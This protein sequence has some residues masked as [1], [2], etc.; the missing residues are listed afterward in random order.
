[1]QPVNFKLEEITMKPEKNEAEKITFNLDTKKAVHIEKHSEKEEKTHKNKKIMIILIS[2]FSVMFFISVFFQIDFTVHNFSLF[3]YLRMVKNLFINAFMTILNKPHNG[4]A[5]SGFY[6]A[7]LVS[8][9]G[10][11]LASSGAVYQGLFRNPIASA[12]IL[13]VYEGGIVAIAIYVLFFM[14]KV[15]DFTL[16]HPDME[17]IMYYL[18]NVFVFSGSVLGIVCVVTITKIAGRGKI[19]TFILV[20]TGAVFSAFL[21]GII[22]YLHYLIICMDDLAASAT[23]GMVAFG[24]FN[25]PPNPLRVALTCVPIAICLIAFIILRRNMNV[26]VFGDE[27]AQALGANIKVLQVVLIILSTIIVS[28]VITFCGKIA[29]LGLV[30]PHITRFFTG[31]DYKI[32]LPASMLTGAIFTLFVYFVAHAFGMIGS[33]SIFISVLGFVVFVYFL[34]KERRR[35]NADWA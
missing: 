21:N 35:K 22:S 9:V 16:A 30:V 15:D 10:A 23:F 27:E 25:L 13:G 11:G 19:S 6:I 4:D 31:P 26:I 28:T 29:W 12:D 17:I 18:K 20:I 34:I 14:Y 2:I 3:N 7:L 24:S 32:L 1:M 33:E 8:L 5:A